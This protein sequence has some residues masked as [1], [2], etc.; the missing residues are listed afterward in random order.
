MLLLLHPARDIAVTG[1]HVDV[2]DA[3]PGERPSVRQ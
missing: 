1:Q 3:L 2:L